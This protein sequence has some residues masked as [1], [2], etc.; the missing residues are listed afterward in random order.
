MLARSTSVLKSCL[1]LLA[2]AMVSAGLLLMAN[3]SMA[4]TPWPGQSG[5]P[6]GY[7]AIGPLGTSTCPAVTSGTAGNPTFIQNCAYSSC[8][9]VQQ[10]H[11][12]FMSVDFNCGA[13]GL[14]VTGTDITFYGS[15]VQSNDQRFYALEANGA[16]I[17]FIYSSTTPLTSLYTSPPGAAWPSAGA[18]SNTTSCSSDTLCI[19]GT[20]GYQHGILLLTSSAGPLWV[21]HSDMWGSGNDGVNWLSQTAQMTFTEN[22]IHDPADASPD[23]YHV[24]GI[25]CYLNDGV[26]P[27]NLLIQGNTVAG[28]GNTNGLACQSATG[29][30]SNLYI[31]QNYFSGFGYTI[32]FCAPGSTRCTN[33]TF[34]NNTYGTD[35][36]PSWGPVYGSSIPASTFWG[37]NKI[38]VTAGTSWTDGDGWTPGSSDNGKYLLPSRSSNEGSSDYLSN[39]TCAETDPSALDFKTQA[40]S[41]T[42]N[43]QT[44]TLR[45][46]GSSALTISSVALT[47]GTDFA[48]SSN[49]CRSS[50]AASANC[51][52]TI[53]FT[54]TAYG[55]ETDTLQI[56]DS[57]ASPASPQLVPL[58][59]LGIVPAV[60][61]SPPTNLKVS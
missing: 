12:V 32:A 22:W 53:T 7:A 38:T 9:S 16:D 4:Q 3:P 47:N 17:Y 26:G 42:S 41:T 29:G 28:I 14:S 31:N 43:G 23:G 51:T 44:V 49:T 61:P 15:R 45:N 1:R 21:D 19:N 52:I 13:G 40:K 55:P 48:I 30:Y 33:S 50:L 59:G 54:P 8:P 39:T 36:V 2:T 46:T 10:S 60:L 25:A 56:K 35:L 57:M 24:D 58:I 34:A 6:V 11:V 27:D 37:C 5:N 20:S 18:G